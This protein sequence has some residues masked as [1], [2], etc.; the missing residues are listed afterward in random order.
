MKRRGFLAGLLVLACAPLVPK[1]R[2]NVRRKTWEETNITRQAFTDIAES[3]K[4]VREA[5]GKCVSL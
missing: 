5:T 4:R 1:I 3:E 2:I